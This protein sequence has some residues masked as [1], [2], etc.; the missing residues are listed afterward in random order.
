MNLNKAIEV[1]EAHNIWRKGADTE[2]TD[3]KQL[4]EAL[5]IAI[6]LLKGLKNG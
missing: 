1:L 6:N 3:P 2:P 4:T 5:E